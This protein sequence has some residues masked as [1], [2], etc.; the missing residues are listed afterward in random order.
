MCK[1]IRASA[2]FLS[3]VLLAASGQAARGNAESLILTTQQSNVESQGSFVGPLPSEPQPLSRKE[4]RRKA[5]P[6]SRRGDPTCRH[7]TGVEEGVEAF[8]EAWA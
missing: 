4:G 3:A 6:L 1:V 8:V 2:A 5:A 7:W